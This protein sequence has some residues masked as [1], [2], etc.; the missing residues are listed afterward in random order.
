MTDS[1]LKRI[2]AGDPNAIQECMER[3]EALVGSVARRILPGG[4]D[5]DDAIQEV[6]LDIWQHADRFDP[7]RGSEVTFVATI[8]RRRIIDRRRRK[9]RD[10]PSESIDEAIH[11]S[12]KDTPIPE[13]AETREAAD[14]IMA[15][16]GTIEPDRRRILELSLLQGQTHEEMASKLGIPLG[17]VKS[18]ARRGLMRLRELLGEDSDAPAT[19]GGSK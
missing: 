9:M 3:Y 4:A 2:A 12:G 17:T 15:L 16:L 18:H 6:F 10:P 14:R 19:D 7:T 11:P 1:V 5:V 13:V 8:A